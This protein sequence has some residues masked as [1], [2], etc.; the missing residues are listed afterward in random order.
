MYCIIYILFSLL[1]ESCEL[2]H[3]QDGI[4]VYFGTETQQYT[5]IPLYGHYELDPNLVNGRPFFKMDSY[6]FWWDG[7]ENWWI[8]P[9]SNI[10]QSYGFAYY[11][12][13]VYCPSLLSEFEWVIWDGSSYIQA[14]NH[15]GITCIIA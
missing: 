9:D 3:C 15:F 5:S 2:N 6:G 8:G 11:E 7:I 4:Q 10:G 14:G 13:D 1:V 12:K